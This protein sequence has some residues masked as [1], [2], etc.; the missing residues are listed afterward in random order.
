M[1]VEKVFL[2]LFLHTDDKGIGGMEDEGN[3][4][5]GIVAFFLVRVILLTG[6]QAGDE[7][8]SPGSGFP[9]KEL[10]VIVHRLS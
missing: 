10:G 9:I 3:K 6:I 1:A 2:V 5:P 4:F 8:K 7:F